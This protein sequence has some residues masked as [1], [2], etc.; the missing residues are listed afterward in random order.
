MSRRIIIEESCEHG[1]G[2]PHKICG[3]H[4]C[5]HDPIH[6]ANCPGG[7]R[8]ILDGPSDE[9]VERAAKAIYNILDDLRA[10]ERAGLRTNNAYWSM[11]LSRAALSAALHGGEEE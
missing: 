7:S 4:Y 3:L 5:T 10:D 1:P 11:L 6:S 9:M 8:S 2:G